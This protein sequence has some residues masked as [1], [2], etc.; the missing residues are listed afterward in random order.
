[1][2][3]SRLHTCNDEKKTEAMHF[4]NWERLI[5]IFLERNVFPPD[6][7]QLSERCLVFSAVVSTKIC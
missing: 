1:M 6:V 2:L 3:H 7:Y 5:W 4:R